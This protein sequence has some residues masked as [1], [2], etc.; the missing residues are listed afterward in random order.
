MIYRPVRVEV[1]VDGDRS[2]IARRLRHLA[3]VEVVAQG[4]RIRA[5]EQG[6]G[7]EVPAVEQE[8]VEHRPVAEFLVPLDAEVVQLSAAPVGEIGILET[9]PRIRDRHML[10]GVAS[11]GAS[12]RVEAR[13]GG[14]VT[15]ILKHWDRHD[16]LILVVQPAGPEHERPAIEIVGQGRRDLAAL[17]GLELRRADTVR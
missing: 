14:E 1:P 12:E 16:E 4:P 5:R 17:V 15:A 11:I 2:A 3:T 8:V 6:I 10:D 13:I 9:A 7:V